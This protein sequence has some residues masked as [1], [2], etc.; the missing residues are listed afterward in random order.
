M[1]TLRSFAVGGLVLLLTAGA[2]LE[3]AGVSWVRGHDLLRN[4]Q[5]SIR[6]DEP[7]HTAK[8]SF[9]L[10]GWC[11][12]YMIGSLNMHAATTTAHSIPER[13]CL[14]AG[15]EV[16]QTIRV[17]VRYLQAHPERLHWQGTPLVAAALGEA[18]PCAPPTSGPQR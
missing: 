4:C 8:V 6:F 17:L 16:G 1:Q 9:L 11:Q 18:F 10:A 15:V 12:G 7:V 14:P 5:E 13:F 3:A 2:G